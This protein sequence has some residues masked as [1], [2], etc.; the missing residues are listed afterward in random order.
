MSLSC[1]GSIKRNTESVHTIL[2]FRCKI[3]YASAIR[4][5][6]IFRN[7]QICWVTDC[8]NKDAPKSAETASEQCFAWDFRDQTCTWKAFP[9]YK[10]WS[11]QNGESNIRRLTWDPPAPVLMRSCKSDRPLSM[12]KTLQFPI[13]GRRANTWW[14]IIQIPKEILEESPS[15]KKKVSYQ[16]PTKQYKSYGR[17]QPCASKRPK[18]G[19]WMPKKS[20]TPTNLTQSMRKARM[21][22]NDNFGKI[23]GAF[24]TLGS[25]FFGQ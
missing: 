16:I 17:T 24:Q 9:S 6:L 15:P 18:M 4:R 20:W 5:A 13:C 19:L 1:S 21:T 7:L 22:R 10:T 25:F 8:A 11:G 23:Q 12:L 14:N 3:P 2:P